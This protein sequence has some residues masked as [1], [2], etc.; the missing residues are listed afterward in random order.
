MND[1]TKFSEMHT[2][3]T[4]MNMLDEN[5]HNLDEKIYIYQVW[6]EHE[7]VNELINILNI[8]NFVELRYNAKGLKPNDFK[9]YIEYPRSFVI[10][11]EIRTIDQSN[12]LQ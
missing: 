11:K 1:K 10:T 3:V 4:N 2:I 7:I 6:G 5:I 12:E 9:Y 8:R